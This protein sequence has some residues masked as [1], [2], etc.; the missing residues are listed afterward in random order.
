MY[1][2]NLLISAFWSLLC[3]DGPTLCLRTVCRAAGVMMQD[4]LRLLSVSAS[5]LR[6]A[7]FVRT[8][9]STRRP[10]S[11][12]IRQNLKLVI[13]DYSRK[14]LQRQAQAG[15][16]KK[17]A[18]KNDLSR[19]N[20]THPLTSCHSQGRRLP[21]ALPRPRRSTTMTTGGRRPTGT[22]GRRRS[23][24]LSRRPQRLAR[25]SG[26][27]RRRRRRRGARARRVDV[28]EHYPRGRCVHDG[29]GRGEEL[30]ARDAVEEARR[31]DAGRGPRDRPPVPRL[32]HQHRAPPP[33]SNRTTNR[34]LAHP[35]P[36]RPQCRGF[37]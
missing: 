2:S 10:K 36:R 7:S 22:S 1:V 30:R 4:V 8:S 3:A 29:Q 15:R 26:W 19:L 14:A 33:R 27:C 35:P 9:P 34:P 12:H 21:S 32:G 18:F 5:E 13:Y 28:G 16:Y 17:T 24:A 6:Q 37:T 31:E 25:R 11:Y 23:C 20:S